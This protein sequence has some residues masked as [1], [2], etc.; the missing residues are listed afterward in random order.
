MSQEV[1]LSALL[2][3]SV[4]SFNLKVGCVSSNVNHINK[5]NMEIRNPLQSFKKYTSEV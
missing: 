4:R 5:N 3:W 1:D 2:N